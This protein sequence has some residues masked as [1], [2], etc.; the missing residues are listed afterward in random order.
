MTTN[1]PTLIAEIVRASG[2]CTACD[3]RF[4]D[5]VVARFPS[6]GSPAGYAYVELRYLAE[7]FSSGG[8]RDDVTASAR[9]TR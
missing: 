8:L 7:L 6:P 1:Q 3:F 2:Y 4:T 5:E 9:V